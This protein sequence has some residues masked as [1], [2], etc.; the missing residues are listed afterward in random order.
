LGAVYLNGAALHVT[1]TEF[2][3]VSF[4]KETV[5]DY[6]L[7]GSFRKLDA[8]LSVSLR[9]IFAFGPLFHPTEPLGGYLVAT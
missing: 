2:L 3:A 7:R 5:V 6:T 1:V 8:S 4:F 9:Q